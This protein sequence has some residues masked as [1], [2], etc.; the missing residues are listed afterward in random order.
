M[1]DKLSR[2]Q[3]VSPGL[4]GKISFRQSPGSQYSSRPVPE[5]VEQWLLSTIRQLQ[6]FLRQST[7]Q[8]G[9]GTSTSDAATESYTG[10]SAS[11]SVSRTALAMSA[12][13]IGCAFGFTA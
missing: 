10:D 5:T 11:L 2:Y 6:L 12:I 13:V 9:N 3:S 7:T 1:I 4:E 8:N